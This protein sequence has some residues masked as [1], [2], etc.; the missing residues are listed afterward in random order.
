MAKSKSSLLHEELFL[1]YAP[2][3]KPSCEDCGTGNEKR[4]TDGFLRSKIRLTIHH[5]DENVRN[6]DPSNL[7]T[8]CRKCHDKLHEAV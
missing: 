8:L 6:N 2:Y 4:D 7:S 5:I 3:K 1:E